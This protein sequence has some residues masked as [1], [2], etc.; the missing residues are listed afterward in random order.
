MARCESALQ[1][2]SDWRS[3]GD[4]A[5]LPDDGCFLSH[6]WTVHPDAKRWCPLPGLCLCC[7]AALDLFRGR[8]KPVWQQPCLRREPHFKGVF[9]QDDPAFRRGRGLAGRLW[10]CLHYSARD[11]AVLWD[12]SGDCHASPA[13][14]VLTCRCDGTRH[15]TVVGSVECEVP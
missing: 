8:P 7:S 11:D 15:R 14:L 9:P 3:V 4:L 12:R 5:A 1:A 10:D 6:I 2:N 13:T